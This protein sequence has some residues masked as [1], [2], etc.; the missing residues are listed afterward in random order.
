M[1]QLEDPRELERKIEQASRIASRV[2]DQTTIQ[3]LTAWVDELKQRLQ[4][5]IA[6]R[7]KEKIRMRAHELWEQHGRPVGRDEE[8]WLR[9]E[10]ELIDSRKE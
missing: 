2:N 10:S 8:F 4:K 7:S 5:R 9:A 1:D 6:R 3:R